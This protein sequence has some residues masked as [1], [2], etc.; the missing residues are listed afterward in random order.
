MLGRGK[1]EL[2]RTL[3]F[4]IPSP[5]PWSGRSCGGS[6]RAGHPRARLAPTRE[7]ATQINAT[8]E[9]LAAATA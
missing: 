3:A 6:R 9:P 7:L 8:L 2:G 1:T 4:S 5:R